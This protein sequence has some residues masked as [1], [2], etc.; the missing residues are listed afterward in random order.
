MKL[1]RISSYIFVGSLFGFIVLWGYLP[2]LWLMGWPQWVLLI[3]SLVGL[4]MWTVFSLDRLSLW[5]KKRS[6]RFGIGL[7]VTAVGAIVILGYVNW[8]AASRNAKKDFTLNKMHTLSDQTKSIVK[9]LTEEVSLTVWSTSLERMSGNISI[10]K[11]L[12]NY[13]QHSGGKLTFQVKNPNED[14]AGATADNVKRDNIIIARSKSGREARV[15]SFTDTKGEEQITNAIIQSVKGASKKTL[16]FVTGHGEYALANTEAGGLSTIKERLESS[17]YTAQEISLASSDS[18]PKNCEAVVVAGPKGD[19]LEHEAKILEAYLASAGKVI[20][21]LGPGTAAGWQKLGA[22]YG[23][24][25]RKDLI[26]DPR[27]NPPVAIATKNYSQEVDI[28]KAF[29][30]MVIMPQVSSLT[31]PTKDPDTNTKVRTFVSS[32][33]Y[34]Y[35]KSGELRSLRD[36]RKTSNDLTGPLPVAV[37]IQ[38]TLTLSTAPSMKPVKAPAPPKTGA[39]SIRLWE[40]VLGVTPAM[41]QEHQEIEAPKDGPKDVKNEM[42]LIVFSNSSFVAN[43]YVTQAG[44]LD[45]FLNTVNFVMKDQDLI[46]IRPRE[47]RQAALQLSNENIKQVW[48]TILILAGLFALGGIL[49]KRRQSV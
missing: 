2:R 1:D 19:I 7:V 23:V 44:N 36:I 29:G 40:R 41:A 49:A 10:R 9:N 39:S 30:A 11:L 22:K 42:N 12:E 14:V 18:V 48:A 46:G 4:V 5:L 15:E 8:F 27:V 38:K 21:L 24:Q 32:E 34:T 35:A 37:L 6:T 31:V 47:L 25:L 43:S 17:S 26:I 13:K 28:T 16:C 3:T 45:L 20:A 33:S